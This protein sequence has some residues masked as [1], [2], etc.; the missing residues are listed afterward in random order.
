MNIEKYTSVQRLQVLLLVLLTMLIFAVV[1][2]YPN[3]ERRSRAQQDATITGDPTDPNE[4]PFVAPTD[5][6]ADM[7]QREPWPPN[8]WETPNASPA[9]PLVETPIPTPVPPSPAP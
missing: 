7:E 1:I 6:P 2:K 4:T 9:D 5:D 8:F 3:Q